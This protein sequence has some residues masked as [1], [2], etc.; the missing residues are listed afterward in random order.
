MKDSF[1]EFDNEQFGAY[2]YVIERIL[3]YTGFY[4]SLLVIDDSNENN[5]SDYKMKWI[6]NGEIYDTYRIVYGLS[7]DGEDYN[8]TIV[9][10][11]KIPKNYLENIPKKYRY[12]LDRFLPIYVSIN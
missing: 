12:D 8:E 2:N 1:K 4:P 6:K 5:E 11:N 9:V 3:D 7:P 10:Y